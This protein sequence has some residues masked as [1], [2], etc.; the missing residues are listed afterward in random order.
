MVA[1]GYGETKLL[2]E[3]IDG[4]T[5]TEEQHEKNRR[6]EFRIL[7]IMSK[8]AANPNDPPA[9]FKAQEPEKKPEPESRTKRKK[10][11]QLRLINNV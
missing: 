7:E 8:A 5:C 10:N 9:D 4:A 11:P 1:K 3:C 2:N 6:T